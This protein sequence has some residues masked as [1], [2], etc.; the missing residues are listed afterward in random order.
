MRLLLKLGFRKSWSVDKH[1]RLMGDLKTRTA[2]CP[3]TRPA[4]SALS[5]PRW[6]HAS[7]GCHC[8]GRHHRNTNAG[9]LGEPTP[10]PPVAHPA[11][12]FECACGAV[13]AAA[14]GPAATAAAA[15]RGPAYSIDR[16]R[17]VV[18]ASAV[19]KGSAALVGSMLLHSACLLAFDDQRLVVDSH[20]R[21]RSAA[22]SQTA[23][24]QRVQQRGRGADPLHRTFLNT[25]HTR[26][27]AN[28][29]MG[30]VCD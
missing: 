30:T 22:R 5:P 6:A 15:A 19:M 18:A 25:T 9:C 11:E 1:G 26:N 28:L 7:G 27:H 8:T 29:C 21:S 23:V 12:R 24:C 10:R 3:H 17:P 13:A 20:C 14:R 4:H 16:L 2:W